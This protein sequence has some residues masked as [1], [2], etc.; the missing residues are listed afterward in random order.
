MDAIIQRLRVVSCSVIH[1][2]VSCTGS[3]STPLHI[4]CMRVCIV[5]IMLP[6][7]CTSL[8]HGSHPAVRD[9]LCL[10]GLLNKVV[11][12]DTDLESLPE[13]NALARALARLRPPP[14]NRRA[15]SLHKP[16]VQCAN[17]QQGK[18]WTSTY[19]DLFATVCWW[20]V[21]VFHVRERA[22][23]CVCVF[24]TMCR[25]FVAVFHVRE[26][27][28]VCVCVTLCT[29]RTVP[30]LSLAPMTMNSL[31][32]HHSPPPPSLTTT[33]TTTITA[34]TTT[35]ACTTYNICTTYTSTST[36][37]T[38]ANTNA[39]NQQTHFFTHIFKTRSLLAHTC[40]WHP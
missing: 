34:A 20:L 4:A 30:V 3:Y 9:S 16:T 21:A 1:L 13:P 36:I 6:V 12:L 28:S 23:V 22:S 17:G 25:W 32:H 29:H 7:C 37:F 31:P 19:Y 39:T 8:H 10:N 27:A 14:T 40:L 15:A 26:R 35:S 24:A 2:L 38:R 18:R 5:G 11:V 33:S